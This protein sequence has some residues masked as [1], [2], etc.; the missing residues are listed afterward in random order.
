MAGSHVTDAMLRSGYKLHL[1]RFGNKH[2]CQKEAGD[3]RAETSHKITSNQERLIH[4][5]SASIRWC[6]VCL[7]LRL[8]SSS[9]RLSLANA[10]SICVRVEGRDSPFSLFAQ[11]DKKKNDLLPICF[12]IVLRHTNFICSIY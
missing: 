3:T 6:V 5:S 8:L 12:E 10:D 2:T 1:R 7:C 11:N 4:F 9:A